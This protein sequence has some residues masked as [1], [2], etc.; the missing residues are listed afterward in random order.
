M[1]KVNEIV[2]RSRGA[3]KGNQ[4]AL[5]HGFYR[6]H[7]SD[8]E[9]ADLDTALQ[10]GLTDEIAMLRVALRRTF[11]LTKK[12]PDLDTSL[13]ALSSLGFACTHLSNLLRTHKYLT[14]DTKTTEDAISTAISQV[15][16]EMTK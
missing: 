1:G 12:S 13:A 8:L 5:K 4:N 11:A 10:E 16:L 9:V 3:P 7:M 6:K 14:G 15:I 2:K